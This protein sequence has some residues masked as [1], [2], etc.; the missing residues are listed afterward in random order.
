MHAAAPGKILLEAPTAGEGATCTSCAHCPWMAMNGLR[1]LAAV[2]ENGGNEIHIEESI[3]VQ[4]PAVDPAHA[5]LRRRRK[6]RS[7]PV[8]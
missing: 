4:G 7:H 1:N 5:G 8:G 3:R 6:G 2:L